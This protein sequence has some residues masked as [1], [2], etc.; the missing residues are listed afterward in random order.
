[1]IDDKFTLLIIG[2][3]SQIAVSSVKEN[4]VFEINV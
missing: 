1:M 3:L 2:A 4:S